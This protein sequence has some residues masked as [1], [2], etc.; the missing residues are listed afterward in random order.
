MQKTKLHY[1]KQ[2]WFY[3]YLTNLNLA[4]NNIKSAPLNWHDPKLQFPTYI[5]FSHA[6]SQMCTHWFESR[7][8]LSCMQVCHTKANRTDWACLHWVRTLLSRVVTLMASGNSML[9]SLSSLWWTSSKKWYYLHIFLA[10][11]SLLQTQN[12]NRKKVN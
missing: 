1:L 3:L 4:W 7:R 12:A 11:I 8:V 9:L 10:E 5:W 6:Q 2:M